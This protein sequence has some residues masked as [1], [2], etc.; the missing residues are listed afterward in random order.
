[1]WGR[2]ANST[3]LVHDAIIQSL[4]SFGV[5]LRPFRLVKAEGVLGADV[6]KQAGGNGKPPFLCF[7]RRTDEDLVFGGYKVL[8]SAQRKTRDAV[9][10]H[11][12][13]LMRA[14]K[15]APQLP[16]IG[17]L[18]S[19]RVASAE[20]AEQMA[21]DLGGTLSIRWVQGDLSS[22]ERLRATVIA[23]QKFGSHDW[24]HRR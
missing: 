8:G 18:S 5:S 13:L 7:Q 24:L 12:S 3:R 15:W 20:L 23:E 1:M 2:G 21:R 10:Q 4:D 19:R 14:S 9:L 17:E 16:G 11:G 6:G 22:Q